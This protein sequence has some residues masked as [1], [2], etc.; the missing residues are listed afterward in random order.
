MLAV[1]LF[2]ACV[3]LFGFWF[4]LVVWL[5]VGFGLGSFAV[6]FGWMF[7]GCRLAGCLVFMVVSGLRCFMVVG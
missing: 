6:G 2:V 7:W 3:G 4:G 1:W 5:V